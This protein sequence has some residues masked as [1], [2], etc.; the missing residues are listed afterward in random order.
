[1]RYKGLIPGLRLGLYFT[2]VVGLGPGFGE[3]GLVL[4]VRVQ[5]GFNFG[6]LL[7]VGDGECEADGLGV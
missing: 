1:M 3:F 2:L 5:S 7:V 4:N 6:L